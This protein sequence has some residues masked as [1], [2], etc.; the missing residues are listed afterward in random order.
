MVETTNKTKDHSSRSTSP[1]IS[2]VVAQ[3]ESPIRRT[4]S[5]ISSS[6]LSS[7]EFQQI[8]QQI[9][10]LRNQGETSQGSS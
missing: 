7:P 5:D 9:E 10:D 8:R 2:F 3:L 6:F 4:V 1:T